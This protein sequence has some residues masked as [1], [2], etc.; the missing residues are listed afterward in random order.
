MPLW[1]VWDGRELCLS[2]FGWPSNARQLLVGEIHTV[3]L[4]MQEEGVRG[5]RISLCSCDVANLY[6]SDA[7]L[8]AGD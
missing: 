3:K 5:P 4:T 7:F 8:V 2:I 1:C 6:L